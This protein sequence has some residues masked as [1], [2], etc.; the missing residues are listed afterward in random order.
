M[1]STSYFD[2]FKKATIFSSSTYN[3]ISLTLPGRKINILAFNEP[4]I[5]V[6]G[7]I[8]TSIF[9]ESFLDRRGQS[10]LKN[11]C[12]KI[13][14]LFKLYQ[15]KFIDIIISQNEFVNKKTEN[16][17]IPDK[18]KIIDFFS[19]DPCS[20]TLFFD[21]DDN[22]YWPDFSSIMLE[23]K[24]WNVDKSDVNI[25][26]YNEVF[27]CMFKML[28]SEPLI[29][30]PNNY[31]PEKDSYNMYK[32]L[33]DFENEVQLLFQKNHISKKFVINYKSL[34]NKIQNP[35][36]AGYGQFIGSIR[37]MINC[38]NWQVIDLLKI[39]MTEF[40]NDNPDDII[41]YANLFAEAF[42]NIIIF[43]KDYKF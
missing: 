41:K 13:S 7:S 17:N 18:Q 12:K 15:T 2:F 32:F 20:K 11:Y 37:E 1:C 40:F 19:T 28:D 36:T 30:N 33:K 22:D 10:S 27:F 5:R 6:F 9:I 25:K 23:E 26:E 34:C 8:F 43:W 31:G 16:T 38:Y 4:K 14:D 21:N 39:P 29:E 24:F 35:I 3:Q 42:G